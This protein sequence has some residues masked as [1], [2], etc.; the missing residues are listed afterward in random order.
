MENL[1]KLRIL[2]KTRDELEKSRTESL[3][4]MLDR[5]GI[6]YHPLAIPVIDLPLDKAFPTEYLSEIATNFS[7]REYCGMTL[8]FD[9]FIPKFNWVF[10]LH[11]EITATPRDLVAAALRD[12][13]H[14]HNNTVEKFESLNSGDN[15]ID[16]MFKGKQ[17]NIRNQIIEAGEIY[18][19][20]RGYNYPGIGNGSSRNQMSELGSDLTFD[21][22]NLTELEKIISAQ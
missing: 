22:N 17:L 11:Q 2:G 15:K 21:N 12:E 13:I 20:E 16:V 1:L 3:F 18:F 10:N 9:F 14:K 6:E 8:F 19:N 4:A 5:H 7:F